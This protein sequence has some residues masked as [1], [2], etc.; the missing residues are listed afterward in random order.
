MTTLNEP[1]NFQDDWYGWITNQCGHMVLGQVLFIVLSC[2]AFFTIGEFPYRNTVWLAIAVGYLVWEF[3]IQ[4]GYKWDSV[5]DSIFVCLYGAGIP[6]M[7]F[8]EVTPGSL[9]FT[10]DLQNIIPIVGLFCFHA[11]VGVF[12]RIYA[13]EDD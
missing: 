9:I 2:V 7:A 8:H 10:G 11:T 6:S 5:E 13:K 12:V 3:V 4:R 1:D